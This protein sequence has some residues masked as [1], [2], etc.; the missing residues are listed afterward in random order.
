MPSAVTGARSTPTG[1]A[2]VVQRVSLRP[3]K[4][5]AKAKANAENNASPKQKKGGTSDPLKSASATGKRVNQGKSP[6]RKGKRVDSRKSPKKR[7][8]KGKPKSGA[9]HK[10]KGIQSR[11]LTKRPNENAIWLYDEV[12][13]VPSMRG[14][15]TTISEMAER[16]LAAIKNSAYDEDNDDCDNEEYDKL[17]YQLF[18][19]T[20]EGKKRDVNF[21]WRML[22]KAQDIKSDSNITA[23]EIRRVAPYFR[24]ASTIQLPADPPK[25]PHDSSYASI[26]AHGTPRASI[27]RT[28]APLERTTGT[29]SRAEHTN[30]MKFFTA[31]NFIFLIAGHTKNVADRMFNTLKGVFRKSQIWSMDVLY[32]KLASRTCE[33]HPYKEGD[34]KKYGEFF[35]KFYK[36]YNAVL[37]YHMFSCSR[38]DIKNNNVIIRVQEYDADDAL[39]MNQKMILASD[40]N[41]FDER[42]DEMKDNPPVVIDEKGLNVYKIFMLWKNHRD[43]LTEFWQDKVAPKPTPNQLSI[44]V[45][46]QQVRKEKNEQI[47]SV[48]AR[49]AK[50]VIILNKKMS[51]E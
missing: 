25:T 44:V 3:K 38:D 34:F 42:A 49:A 39:K 29:P 21:V 14:P 35:D 6:Q 28:T 45:K 46:E 47:K 17:Q 1:G 40:E 22:E 31:V 43:L 30:A 33:I 11:P 19:I 41:T 9:K 50:Q 32:D 48:K 16:I 24:D 4:A 13:Q 18:V 5:S 26:V 37:K 23:D 27:E 12:R 36:K 10:N 15:D 20:G 51:A 8:G 2:G 7:A